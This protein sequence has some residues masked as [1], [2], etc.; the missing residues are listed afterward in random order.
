MSAQGKKESIRRHLAHE[1]ARLLADRTAYDI[2]N[3]RRKA[4]AR[5]GMTDK[6]L[7]PSPI[8]VQEALAAHQRLFQPRQSEHLQHL[9]EQAA[10]AMRSFRA[11]HPRLIGPVLDG[12]ADL[13][14][15]IT[16]HLVAED[17]IEVIHALMEQ[18]IPWH[19]TER[20]LRYADG[21]R[22]THPALRFM[23]GDEELELIVL[24]PSERRQPPLNP[25]TERP[26]GGADID[27]LQALLDATPPNDDYL[28]EMGT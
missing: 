16:L 5:A 8:E 12:N 2:E 19:E 28:C 15:C 1:A 17:P 7:W 14:S 6:R 23:A 18:N 25:V 22:R 13:G 3:A 10:H 11:F 4:A 9:R 24:T 26:D 27:T 21:S 20:N